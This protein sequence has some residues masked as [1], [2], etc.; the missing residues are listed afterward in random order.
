MSGFIPGP[1]AVMPGG[2][3]PAPTSLVGHRSQ[4]TVRIITSLG[5]VG[6]LEAAT[7]ER[8]T[9]AL[10]ALEKVSMHGLHPVVIRYKAAMLAYLREL[11]R[12]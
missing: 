6:A 9:Q 11:Y 5:K 7:Q 4:E 12:A 8:T 10:T 2:M 1:A 3:P